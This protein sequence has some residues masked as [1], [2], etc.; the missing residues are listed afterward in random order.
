MQGIVQVRKDTT[1]NSHIPISTYIKQNITTIS[2]PGNYK[3]HFKIQTFPRQGRFFR[4]PSGVRRREAGDEAQRVG[5]HHG[6]GTPPRSHAKDK[7][8]QG[9]ADVHSPAEALGRGSIS[10]IKIG[11]FVG[12]ERPCFLDNAGASLLRHDDPAAGLLHLQEAHPG[13]LRAE[14]E[15]QAEGEADGGEQGQVIIFI[16][17]PGY[18][19]GN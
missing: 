5:R 18:V 4:H 2:Q 19:W 16:L 13:S 15:G 11:C 12:N 10:K 7:A 1:L 17:I 14:E 8:I 9:P 3:N 6:G